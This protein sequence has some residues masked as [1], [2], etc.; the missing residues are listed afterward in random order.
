[1]A[2]LYHL[3]LCACM[4]RSQ[5]WRSL[6]R[7]S[8]T[9][10]SSEP[11]RKVGTCT[12]VHKEVDRVY[13]EACLFTLSV[14]EVIC[15]LSDA[16]GQISTCVCAEFLRIELLHY[17]LCLQV[18]NPTILEAEDLHVSL[19]LSVCGTAK[20]LSKHNCVHCADIRIVLIFLPTLA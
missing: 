7:A 5:F 19:C 17:V 2:T 13:T 20:H 10:R 6:C 3:A 14:F 4:H 15:I 18:V 11:C 16:S 12:Q 9:P 8:Q 1:M